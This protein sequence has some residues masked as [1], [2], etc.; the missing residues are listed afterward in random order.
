MIENI[1]R[2]GLFMIVAQTF[3]HFAAGQQYEKYMKIIAGI[4]VLLLF[5]RPFSLPEED[6]ADRWQEEM[7]RLTEQMERQEG[8]WQENM[9]GTDYGIGRDV[10]E[11]FEE[12][13]KKRINGEM[14]SGN[15][16]AADVEVGWKETG[17][18]SKAAEQETVLDYVRITLQ[19]AGQDGCDSAAVSTGEPIAVERIQVA[20]QSGQR[21]EG[22]KKEGQDTEPASGAGRQD[23]DYKALQ[24]TGKEKERE[25]YRGMFARILGIEEE[26]VEVIYGGGR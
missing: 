12:E 1:K 3:M 10:T 13:I 14:P 18:Q 4:I 7:E 2:I 6:F 8:L 25:E 11:R 15:Y 26:K 23:T 5:V 19:P 22:G 24:D 17:E 21:A 20:I 16:R 9:S